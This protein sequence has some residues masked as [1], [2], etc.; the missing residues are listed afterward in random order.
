MTRSEPWRLLVQLYFL[1]RIGISVNIHSSMKVRK[2]VAPTTEEDAPIL[3]PKTT[4]I[5]S[6]K[7]K[8]VE[9]KK[10]ETV[11]ANATPEWMKNIQKKEKLTEFQEQPKKEV[12]WMNRNKPTLGE[13]EIEAAENIIEQEKKRLSDAKEKFG[14]EVISPFDLE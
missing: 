8:P 7:E 2:D 13:Q 11:R 3:S 6:P 14:K 10:D 9:K 4:P 12:G 5:L 1:P